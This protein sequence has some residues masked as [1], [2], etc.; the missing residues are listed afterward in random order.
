M[1]AHRL[2]AGGGYGI[3]VD[4]GDRII[5]IG[6]V[7]LTPYQVDLPQFNGDVRSRSV[8]PQP[9]W[10]DRNAAVVDRQMEDIVIP[11]GTDR[12]DAIAGIFIDIQLRNLY[13]FY[14]AQVQCAGTV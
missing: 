11:V 7:D 12:F 3:T 8:V 14:I 9:K 5:D 4:Q 2:N 1:Y 10:I 6:I 13:P